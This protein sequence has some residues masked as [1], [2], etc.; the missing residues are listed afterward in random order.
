M[1]NS[2]LH[3]KIRSNGFINIHF[4]N[5]VTLTRTHPSLPNLSLKGP[6]QFFNP[7]KWTAFTEPENTSMYKNSIKAQGFLCS[8]SL[9]AGTSA[10][11]LLLYHSIKLFNFTNPLPESLLQRTQGQAQRRKCVQESVGA[12]SWKGHPS[13]RSLHTPAA[14]G[15]QTQHLKVLGGVCVTPKMVWILTILRQRENMKNIWSNISWQKH[16]LDKMAQHTVQL[17]IQSVQHWRTHH[18]P[19]EIIPMADCSRCEFFLCSIGS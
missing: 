2:I 7:A 18:C 6:P 16:R 5:S 13:T 10:Q 17:Q 9:S 1:G 15:L 3:K 14:K 4:R 12:R 19:G 11:D 8:G